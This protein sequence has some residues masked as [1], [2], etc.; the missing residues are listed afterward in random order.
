MNHIKYKLIVLC[1]VIVFLMAFSLSVFAADL[2][3]LSISLTRATVH[4][5]EEVTMNF[6]FGQPLGAYTFEID[7]DDN[8]FE[9]VG[10]SG[11]AASVSG[12]T[13]IVTFYDT[14]GGSNP[15]TVM[16]VTFRAITGITTSNP[17]QFMI[18]RN[19]IG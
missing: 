7:F 6:D 13:V 1:F 16:S 14:T 2:D 12:D 5:G 18:T 8:L 4:P 9:Y 11:G 17:T 3:T 19:W 10:N 15:S